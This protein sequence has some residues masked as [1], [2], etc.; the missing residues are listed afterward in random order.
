MIFQTCSFLLTVNSVSYANDDP[1]LFL[2]GSD[3]GGIFKCSMN[4]RDPVPTSKFFLFF[5]IILT[6]TA[7]S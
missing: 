4:S 6:T 3:S 7:I 1:S 2:V 5:K